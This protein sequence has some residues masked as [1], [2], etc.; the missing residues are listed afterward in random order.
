MEKQELKSVHGLITYIKVTKEGTKFD[1]KCKLYSIKLD[2]SEFFYS[3]FG[4]EN[5]DPYSH[6]S[7]GDSVILEYTVKDEYHNI[8]SIKSYNKEIED[9]NFNKYVNN[10][11]NEPIQEMINSGI[12][13]GEFKI[14]GLLY[15]ISIKK[16]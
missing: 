11:V 14:N 15:E 5:D 13:S 7:E 8:K 2:S 16:K 6:Y 9:L 4:K 1:P 12:F 10:D 3:A